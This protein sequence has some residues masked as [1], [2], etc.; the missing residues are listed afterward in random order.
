[1]RNVLVLLKINFCFPF[2]VLGCFFYLIVF[3]ATL[4]EY[5]VN[6]SFV[7]LFSNI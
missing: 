4:T 3:Y 6:K 1:M 7:S 2:G 5:I